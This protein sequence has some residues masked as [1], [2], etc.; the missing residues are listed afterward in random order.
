M[1][2]DQ[3]LSGIY[4]AYQLKPIK[5]HMYINTHT[6]TKCHTIGNFKKDWKQSTCYRGLGKQQRSG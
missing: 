3:K 6:V 2:S 4:Q 5:T 1:F